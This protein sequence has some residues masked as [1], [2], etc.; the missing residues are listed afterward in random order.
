MDSKSNIRLI[1][2]PSGEE[3]QSEELAEA[4][5]GWNCG[6]Y[7]KYSIFRSSCSE[8]DSGACTDRSKRNYCINYSKGKKK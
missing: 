2:Y 3:L 8:W 1:E 5:G 4:L 6:S 7:T